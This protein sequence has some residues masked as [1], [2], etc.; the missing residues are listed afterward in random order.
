MG[1]GQV[2]VQVAV[3]L[4]VALSAAGLLLT[5]DI[6]SGPAAALGMLGI[7]LIAVARRGQGR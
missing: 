5:G 3:G 7:G 2:N 4:L 1:R 6:G